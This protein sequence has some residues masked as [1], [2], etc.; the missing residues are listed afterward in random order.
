MYRTWF[1][2]TVLLAVTCLTSAHGAE[3]ADTNKSDKILQKLDE[4]LTRLGTIER[5][6]LDAARDI[7]ELKRQVEQLQAD[8]ADARSQ[9]G[10]QRSTSAKF[11]P[12]TTP[13]LGTVRLRNDY[14][15][16]MSLTV[17]G[18]AYDLLPGEIRDVAVAAGSFTYQVFGV[19]PV[20]VMRSVGE[21]KSYPIRIHPMG[22]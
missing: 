18:L 20:P 14:P 13:A 15:A 16:L 12:A 3:P 9:L 21:G 5:D 7:R 2:T 10:T 22:Q 19:H 8:V 6:R 4:V 17:N 11:G 1:P